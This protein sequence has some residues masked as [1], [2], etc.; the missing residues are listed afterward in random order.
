MQTRIWTAALAA[1]F[2]LAAAPA[3]ADDDDTVRWQTVIG[4]IQAGNLVF[5]IAGGGQPWSTLG[6]NAR[7]NLATGR[8][9]F[10]VDGL[11]LAGGNTV[12][13]RGTIEEVKGTI[14]CGAGAANQADT[15]LVPLD[16]QG[17]ARFEGQ[18]TSAVPASCTPANVVFLVRVG[19]G[20]WIANGAVR[21]P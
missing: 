14:A 8:V 4:I 6:G 13:T 17:N 5:D 18:L 3:R 11:V 10:R 20:R 15:P 12:G 2:L 1:L 19:A 9:Q 16:E 7:V 21:V